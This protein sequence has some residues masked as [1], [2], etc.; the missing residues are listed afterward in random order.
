[1][2]Q[3]DQNFSF[4][5]SPFLYDVFVSYS[6]GDIDQTGDSDFLRWSKL[7]YDELR[8]AIIP[9][10][11]EMKQLRIFFDENPRLGEGLGLG[12]DVDTTLEASARASAFLLALISPGYLK[13]TYCERERLWWRDGQ[14]NLAYEAKDRF[15][16]LLIWGRPPH[17]DV[18]WEAA[19]KRHDL[20]NVV[21][22]RFFDGEAP[23]TRPHPFGWPGLARNQK[24]IEGVLNVVAHLFQRLEEFRDL[25]RQRQALTQA[26]APLSPT[27]YLHAREDF[28]DAFDAAHDALS[29]R[30][31]VVMPEA[32]EPI[33]IDPNKR[34]TIHEQ[35]TEQLKESNAL[36]VVADQDS[37]RLHDDLKVW[38]HNRNLA[39]AQAEKASALPR[40]L[41]AAILDPIEDRT[42]AKRRRAIVR[43]QGLGWFHLPEP[44]WADQAAQWIKEAP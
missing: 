34:A 4:V 35:R 13:S 27:V 7:F 5:G 39:I 2:Q 23:L 22:A 43:N 30:G 44:D 37:Y 15:L 6:H 1:M 31:F 12:R 33:E 26:I 10:S 21:H 36:I 16:P 41:P 20:P 19:L 32:P 38:K 24:M 9:Y 28:A 40:R 11:D 25:V 8:R 18:S 42:L 14:A 17:P 29:D 3:T